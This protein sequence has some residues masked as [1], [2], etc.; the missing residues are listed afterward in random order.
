MRTQAR[1]SLWS[2]SI[3]VHK[4]NL[5]RRDL[6][7]TTSPV[8]WSQIID[9]PRDGD[10]FDTFTKEQ[11]QVP[12]LSINDTQESQ[13]RHRSKNPHA[14]EHLVDSDVNKR[15]SKRDRGRFCLHEG[16]DAYQNVINES[17]S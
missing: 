8:S 1:H 11:N 2:C 13:D 10:Q 14:R 4:V 12:R 17:G 6:R 9:G 16:Q 5:I 15:G 7:K 3:A